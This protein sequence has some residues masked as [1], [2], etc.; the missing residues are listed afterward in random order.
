[1]ARVDEV[2]LAA[3]G[4]AGLFYTTIYIL[5]LGFSTGVQILIARRHGEKK[6]PRHWSYFRQ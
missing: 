6:I 2:S 5:G 3:V 4:L 1:M